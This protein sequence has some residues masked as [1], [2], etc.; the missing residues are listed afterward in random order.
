MCPPRAWRT[1]AESEEKRESARVWMR[2]K[3]S[4]WEMKIDERGSESESES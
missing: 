2:E 4:E 3:M 1:L